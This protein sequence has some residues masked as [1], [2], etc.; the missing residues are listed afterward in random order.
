M[1]LDKFLSNMGTASRSEAAKA[2]RGGL[3]TVN[4]VP[5]RDVSKHIDPE[6]D[7][8]Y[9]NGKRVTY[10]KF[11]YILLNKPDGV[12]S[13]TEDGRD[14]T[15]LDLLPA[16]L[17]K[18]ELFPC[19]RLDKHTLGLVLITDNGDL[20][21]R[22]LA[23]KSHVTKKYR[24]ES[25]FPLTDEE[26]RTLEEGA[27]LDDGYETKPSEI[28]L[29]DDRKSGTITLT[30]GKYHQIKRMFESVNNKITYLERITF[31]PL[32]LEGVPERG[33]WRYLTES[34]IE[35]LEKHGKN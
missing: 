35:A 8:I 19:G 16:E 30:E 17:R 34:E 29:Y 3:V 24:Y 9:F 5:C 31:G 26:K 33:D 10:E 27:V 14:K 2:A 13:A 22:L 1:R 32:T 15:V 20:A 7:V 18:F 21:H 23:P 4:S 6:R 28:E 11:R 12:V 25:K